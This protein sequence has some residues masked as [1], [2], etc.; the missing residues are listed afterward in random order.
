MG[1]AGL[2]L[3]LGGVRHLGDQFHS[4]DADGADAIEQIDYMFFV[5]EEAVGIK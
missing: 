4:A 5:V 3:M 1:F 2:G